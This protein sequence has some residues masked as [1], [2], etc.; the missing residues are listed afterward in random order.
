MLSFRDVEIYRE[1]RND[2]LREADH[3]RLVRKIPSAWRVR[4]DRIYRFILFKLGQVLIDGGKTL[5]RQY[6]YI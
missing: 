5:Q 3:E 2:R 6:R 1:I 4:S